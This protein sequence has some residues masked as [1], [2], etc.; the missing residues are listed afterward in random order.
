MTASKPELLPCP[1][2]GSL[3]DLEHVVAGPRVS[4][5]T[6]LACG[7]TTD[8]SEAITDDDFRAGDVQAINA[9]NDRAAD[10][11]RI[12]ELQ[13][14]LI[15][16]TAVA[17]TMLYDSHKADVT[18]EFSIDELEQVVASTEHLQAEAVERIYRRAWDAALAQQGKEGET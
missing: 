18:A 6:C 10:K 9:W 13:R 5:G 3:P 15:E 1:F 12:A 17:I 11:A 14:L 4:C 2:C 8:T 7:P 16:A